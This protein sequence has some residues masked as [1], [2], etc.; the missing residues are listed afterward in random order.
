METMEATLPNGSGGD[1]LLL[2]RLNLEG[3]A[4]AFDAGDTRRVPPRDVLRLAHLF[5][6]HGHIDHFVGFDSLIRPRVCRPESLT[7]H[8][9]PGILARVGARL[10]GYTWNLVEGNHFVI[11]VR[12]ILDDRVRVARFD[13]GN[14]F[15]CEDLPEEP[16]GSAA[17]QDQLV[18]LESAALDHHV[19]SQ[20]FAIERPL[21]VNVRED[22]L[23]ARGLRPGPWLGDM[24]RAAEAG[25]TLD[26][27]AKDILSIRRGERIAFVT[28]TICDAVT[29]PRIVGLARDAD[30]F[31]CGAPFL[32]SED[33][34]A[35][36]T[37]HLT[38]AQAGAM[39][40]EAG[41]KVL[42]LFHVSD[43]YGND[44]AQ[45]AEEALDA[46]KGRVDVQ[47]Q[48]PGPIVADE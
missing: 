2:V 28:D 19:V 37:R 9:G 7:V 47:M 34:R 20:G 38:A 5:V 15:M 36:Q 24:K 30:V 14:E 31:A 39:A 10:H 18:S 11:T 33:D 27:V 44:F 4:L 22:R 17:F 6:S 3:V 23:E 45:H 41:A 35:R 16:R 48:L 29:R 8:G 40:A 46:A 26:E 12:E 32:A 42:L 1:S 21:R 43:R 13:S 25:G